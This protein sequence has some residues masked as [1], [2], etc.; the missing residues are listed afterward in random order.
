MA[1]SLG[2]LSFVTNGVEYACI[3]HPE[4]ET[5]EGPRAKVMSTI[6]IKIVHDAED[7]KLWQKKIQTR[8]ARAVE[9]VLGI[10]SSDI[11]F[12]KTTGVNTN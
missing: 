6:A 1:S 12:D 8:W 9:K 2:L 3:W 10:D 4:N 11:E 5:S 7:F